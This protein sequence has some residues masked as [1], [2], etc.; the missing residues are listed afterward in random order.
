LLR[1]GDALLFFD[2]LFDARNLVI[3]FDID[4]NLRDFPLIRLED[5]YYWLEFERLTSLPV[6]VYQIGK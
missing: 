3:G 4:F 6:K 2:T 1:R 5:S